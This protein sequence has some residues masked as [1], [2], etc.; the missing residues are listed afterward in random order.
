MVCR[1]VFEISERND[2]D[3]MIDMNED[4]NVEWK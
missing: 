4:N 3:E 2:V 1:N